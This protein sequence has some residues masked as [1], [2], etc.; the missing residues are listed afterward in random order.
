M[1]DTSLKVDQLLL[2]D[3]A[4]LSRE[5]KLSIIGIFDQIFV[6]QVP[7]SHPKMSLVGFLSGPPDSHHKITVSALD[8]DIKSVLPDQN[9]DITLGS[10]GKTHILLELVNFPIAIPGSYSFKILTGKKSLADLN[11]VV[12]KTGASN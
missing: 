12:H 6:P 3:L 10:S 7:A 4:L 1:S 2:C 11:L 9:L 5:N 8:P